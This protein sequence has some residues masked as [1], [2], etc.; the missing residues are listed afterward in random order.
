MSEEPVVSTPDAAPSPDEAPVPGAG[1]GR[2][3]RWWWVAGIAIAALVVIVLA[4]LASS[5]PDGLERVAED[6]GFI[7][8]AENMVSG[9]LGDYAIPGIDDPAVSTVLS[10]LL[11]LAIV[12]GIMLVVGRVLARRRT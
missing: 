2:L 4:P 6:V 10:G 12:L 11:G 8:R 3:G 1:K 5:D 9:I 7:D